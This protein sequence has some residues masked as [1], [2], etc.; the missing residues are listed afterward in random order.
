MV[1]TRLGPTYSKL[2]FFDVRSDI[3]MFSARGP[4]GHPPADISTSYSPNDWPP[5]LL[6]LK[7][8][9]II[10]FLGTYTFFFFAQFT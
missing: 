2:R 10:Y 8:F 9:C 1:D 7:N 6:G 4:P 5:G 3:E